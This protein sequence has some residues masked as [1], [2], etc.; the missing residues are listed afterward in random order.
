MPLKG[1]MKYIFMV[2]FYETKAKMFGTIISVAAARRGG[3]M[4]LFFLQ[5][6]EEIGRFLSR[7]QNKNNPNLDV[8][9]CH[10]FVL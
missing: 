6:P 3:G 7:E 5:D 1:K 8:D 10:Y 2:N 4:L 9:I